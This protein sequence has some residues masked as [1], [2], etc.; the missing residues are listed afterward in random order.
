MSLLESEIAE[1]PARLKG[2]AAA[3]RVAFTD[4]LM[5]FRVARP[6]ALFTIARG[7]SDAVAA[8]AGYRLTPAL[9]LPVG[10]FAPSLASLDGARPKNGGLWTLAIS[11]SARSP[12]LIA[13]QAAFADAGGV[14]F[15]LV[16]DVNAPLATGADVV[17]DQSA[18]AETSVAATKSFACSLLVVDLWAEALSGRAEGGDERCAAIAKATQEQMSTPLDLSLLESIEAAYVIGRGASLP[19]ANEA[20]L[21]LKETSGL[22]A[23]AVSAAE[24]MH[25]PR[26]I[27]G[28]KLAVLGFAGPGPAGASVVEALKALAEQGSPTILVTAPKLAD[29]L[30]PAAPVPMIAGF[31]AALP[32]L[33]RRR[34]R[35]PENPPSLS[36]VTL[37]R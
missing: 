22:H 34:G 10:S 21:K 13:A 15:A 24:V 14:R 25:G 35:D 20:A 23:E 7:T 27:A 28:K 16:N 2:V 8:Y 11:Q 31:Y 30:A 5:R 12:D 36:K 4:S 19:V 29:A 26:A 18:G 9:N 17:L 6:P 37:T 3:N 1:I 33:A 32:A